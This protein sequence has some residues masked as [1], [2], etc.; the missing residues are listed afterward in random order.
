MDSRTQIVTNKFENRQK[1]VTNHL[2]IFLLLCQSTMLGMMT[3]Y[4]V[5][6]IVS[7]DTFCTS[8]TVSKYRIKCHELFKCCMVCRVYVLCNLLIKYCSSR[9]QLIA[10]QFELVYQWCYRRMEE[11]EEE[12]DM[13]IARSSSPEVSVLLPSFVLKKCWN[14]SLV[15]HLKNFFLRWYLVKYLLVWMLQTWQRVRL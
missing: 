6:M 12:P 8:S 4:T 9:L 13:F 3:N 11:E 10:W 5:I 1:N 15:R 14:A 2:L 7:A